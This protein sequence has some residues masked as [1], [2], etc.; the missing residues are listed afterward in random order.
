MGTLLHSSIQGKYAA[1]H[2]RAS[3]DI[4]PYN[5]FFYCVHGIRETN[6]K[7]MNNCTGFPKDTFVELDAKHNI[8]FKHLSNP[9]INFPVSP[10]DLDAIENEFFGLL[11][12]MECHFFDTMHNITKMV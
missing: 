2:A 11:K 5:F 3:A 4:H 10:L 8:S 9:F 6:Y 12:H 1:A 7:A